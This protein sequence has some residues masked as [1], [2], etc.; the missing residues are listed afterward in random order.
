[1]KIKL[2]K[3]HIVEGKLIKKGAEVE[4]SCGEELVELGI[5]QKSLKEKAN[6]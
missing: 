6:A 4:C 5:A 1:M 3:D 2:K